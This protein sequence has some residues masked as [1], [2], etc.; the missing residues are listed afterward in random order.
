MTDVTLEADKEPGRV[1]DHQRR[2]RRGEVI[3]AATPSSSELPRAIMTSGITRHEHV[4]PEMAIE[5]TRVVGTDR[6]PAPAVS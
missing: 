5:F 4:E 2:H 3:N 1:E 6:A